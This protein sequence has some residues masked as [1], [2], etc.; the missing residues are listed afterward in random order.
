MMVSQQT[1]FEKLPETLGKSKGSLMHSKKRCASNS[2]QL[3]KPCQVAPLL[4]QPGRSS[5]MADPTSDSL[6]ECESAAVISHGAS[7]D[8]V[9]SGSESIPAHLMKPDLQGMMFDGTVG[10]T[11]TCSSVNP[12][13]SHYDAQHQ[14]E[15]FRAGQAGQ[16]PHQHHNQPSG[17]AKPLYNDMFPS[18]D[19]FAY[20][21]SQPLLELRHRSVNS[22]GAQGQDSVCFGLRGTFDSL[23]GQLVQIPAY[24]METQSVQPEVDLSPHVYDTPGMMNLGHSGHSQQQQNSS[25][26]N[27]DQYHQGQAHQQ[28]PQG[29]HH[30]ENSMQELYANC[31]NLASGWNPSFFQNTDYRS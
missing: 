4:G 10:A 12:T 5:D 6:E 2:R 31:G 13:G 28:Q 14:H 24:L 11:L 17:S 16:Q 29:Y 22:V 1:L 18:S 15:A 26:Q 7:A 27:H 23:E 25:S 3:A 8:S 21:P 30:N 9:P 19:P 20:P